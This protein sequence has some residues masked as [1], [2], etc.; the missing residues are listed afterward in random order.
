MTIFDHIANTVT[1]YAMN[2]ALFAVVLLT[3]TIT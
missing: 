3:Y 2:A 1:D